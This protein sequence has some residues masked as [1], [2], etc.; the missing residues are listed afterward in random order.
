ML[1]QSFT[2]LLITLLLE[3]LP[4]S[5][6]YTKKSPVLQV[7][8]SNYDR[9]I[10]RSNH[11]SVSEIRGYLNVLYPIGRHANIHHLGSRVRYLTAKQ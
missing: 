5:G 7:D 10:S 8:S 2:A 11:A 6:L 4:A 3:A 1:K 9:L